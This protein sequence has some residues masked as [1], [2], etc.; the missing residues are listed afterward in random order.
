MLND[1]MG[2]GSF[3]DTSTGRS[4]RLA[5]LATVLVVLPVANAHVGFPHLR[6][7]IPGSDQAWLHHRAALG[8][9][10][11]VLALL[12]MAWA[13]RTNGFALRA[14][15][16]L[17][18]GGGI[19]IACVTVALIAVLQKPVEALVEDS[20]DFGSYSRTAQIVSVT[21]ILWAGVGQEILFRAFAL[22]VVED[23]TKS[24]GAAVLVTS[25]TFAY[26][27]GGFSL[28]LSNFAANLVAALFLGVVFAVTRD[29][30]AVAVPHALLI[31][32]RLVLA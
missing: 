13:A 23:L 22:P 9:A 31:A 19:V 5:L 29:L 20:A 16:H 25:L 24:T 15:R 14:R 6:E 10:H 12:V 4:S 32:V 26:Y 21:A 17:V 7:N 28:G 18:V 2:R 3:V 1:L 11:L 30:W 27:H 8:G